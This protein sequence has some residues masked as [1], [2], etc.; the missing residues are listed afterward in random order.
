M[1]NLTFSRTKFYFFDRTI[2]PG[3][4]KVRL[5]SISSSLGTFNT[6]FS[7]FFKAFQKKTTL[8]QLKRNAE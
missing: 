6:F 1:L 3:L 2:F 8:G 4:L 7:H 5:S